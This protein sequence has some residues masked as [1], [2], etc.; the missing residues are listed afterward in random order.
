MKVFIHSVIAQKLLQEW[1]TSFQVGSGI[2]LPGLH[3]ELALT[4]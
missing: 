1:S 3:P 2:R 4:V